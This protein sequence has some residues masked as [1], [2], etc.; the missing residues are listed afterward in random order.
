MG[1]PKYKKY[2]KDTA[3]KLSKKEQALKDKEQIRQYIETIQ[4][5]LK[6][7][8]KAAKAAQILEQWLKENAKK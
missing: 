2:P 1:A 4:D 8:S 7:P 3:R 6:D 5:T